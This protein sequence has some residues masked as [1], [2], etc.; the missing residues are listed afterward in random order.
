VTLGLLPA[1]VL[2]TELIFGT[3]YAFILVFRPQDKTKF[4][5]KFLGYKSQIFLPNIATTLSKKQRLR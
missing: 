3:H 4:S 1:P 5:T 2:Q